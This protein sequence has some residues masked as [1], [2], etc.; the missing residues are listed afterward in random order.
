MLNKRFATI[1]EVDLHNKRVFIREDLNVPIKNGNITDDTRIKRALP[2]IQK[3]LQANAGI[4]IAS[5][6]GRPKA[7]ECNGDFSLAPVAK[8]LSI[9]L[10]Y[11]VQ[12]CA[13]WQKN[14]KVQA[15]DILLLENI[16]FNLGE[17][18][19]DHGLAQQLAKLCDIF[20]MDAF[21]T[22][23]RAHAST[24]GIAQ[25]APQAVAGPLLLAELN[26]LAASLDKPK[27]PLVAIVGGA[28]VSTKF[29]LLQHLMD[30]VD[31]LIVG[32]GIANT[33][34]KAQGHCVGQSLYEEN[35][36]AQAKRLLEKA[37]KT[38][39]TIPLPKDVVVA[40]SLDQPETATVKA[41]DSV[42][43]NE[44][45]YDV[46][47]KTQADYQQRLQQAKTIV[48]NGPLGVFEIPQFCQGTLA[49]AQ[50][51]AKSPAFSLAGGGDT[52]AALRKF[53][54]T[55]AMSYVSTGG[56]AFLAYLEGRELPA[57]AALHERLQ[58]TTTI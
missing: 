37:D 43:D 42:N 25:F 47:P 49:L 14:G 16:R 38:G 46:G 20:V 21:A 9:L 53:N 4:I 31:H 36:V 24:V 12:L 15:G 7:G 29:E 44:A 6:L 45:I 52:L 23:H 17:T 19:N 5:H 40:T 41:I 33:F 18:E 48:W 11:P 35:W 1:D 26:A 22:T 50:A 27:A 28:K 57:I 34:L 56:G 32:G 51:I 13:D 3:A 58:Q 2:T 55:D 39:V 10:D 8:H 54:L 30:K